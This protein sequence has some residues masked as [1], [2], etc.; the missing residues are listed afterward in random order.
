MCSKDSRSSS[1]KL[2]KLVKGIN[3]KQVK[4]CNSVRE[5]AGQA[6]PDDKSVANGL[7]AH[8]Q[9]SSRF[10]ISSLNRS[11]LKRARNVIHGCRS[12][13]LGPNVGQTIFLT[14]ML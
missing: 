5:A 9:S 11:I 12:F 8:Y 4:T 3:K 10:N 1:S 6:Y 7:A 2:W 14:C 13:D